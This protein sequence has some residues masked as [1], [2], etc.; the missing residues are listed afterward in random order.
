MSHHCAETQGTLPPLGLGPDPNPPPRSQLV[1]IFEH[2][3]ALPI[4]HLQGF[5]S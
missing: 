2:C 3:P 1:P 5:V 4:A